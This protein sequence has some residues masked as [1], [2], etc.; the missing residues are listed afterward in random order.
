MKLEQVLTWKEP[1]ILLND[2]HS[3][4]NGT[5]KSI[6]LQGQY[7]EDCLWTAKMHYINVDK[8]FTYNP[9]PTKNIGSPLFTYL[10]NMGEVTSWLKNSKLI[11]SCGMDFAR[12]PFDLQVR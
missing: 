12:Y 9:T 5:T 7:V 11:L 3:F 6:Q 8:M 4:W 10:N 2:S 1:R